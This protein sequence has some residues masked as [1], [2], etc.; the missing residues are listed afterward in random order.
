MKNIFNTTFIFTV[1]LAATPAFADKA[2]YCKAYARDFADQ[3][4]VDEMSF[5]HKYQI[6]IDACLAKHVAPQVKR[7]EPRV[8]RPVAPSV[9]PA[10]VIPKPVVAAPVVKPVAPVAKV[11]AMAPGSP[12]WNDYCAKK[13]VS[14]NA[15]TGT[16][17]S[18]TGVERK[19]VVSK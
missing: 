7:P 6:A 9:K 4:S 14:F 17:Q 8:F 12:E 1:V 11:L 5:Q 10:I 2:S 13:Y 18:K 16:Y 19:C 3:T 15:K